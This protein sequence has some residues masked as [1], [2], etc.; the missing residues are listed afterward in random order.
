MLFSKK[1]LGKMKECATFKAPIVL[2]EVRTY[3]DTAAQQFAEKLGSAASG[4]ET[5]IE[6]GGFIAAP[7]ALRHPKADVACL[8]ACPDTSGPRHWLQLLSGSTG[9]GCEMQ[10]AASLR[11]E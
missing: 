2:A 4:A 8:K 5:L 10:Q 1:Q 3:A 9:A 11:G 6:Q 7:K